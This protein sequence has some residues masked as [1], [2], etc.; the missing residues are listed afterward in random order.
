MKLV[1]KFTL[2]FTFMLVVNTNFAASSSVLNPPIESTTEKQSFKGK[3]KTFFQKKVVQRVKKKIKKVKDSWNL[4]KESKKKGL[5]FMTTL[6]LL[7]TATFVTLQ[8]V[9][10]ISWPWI[11]VLSPLWI[12]LALMILLALVA[13]IAVA[14]MK[15]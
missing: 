7:L 6:I 12:P 14:A 5:G 15:K 13:L 2:L 10:V 8:L 3:V 9:G 1:V 4:Y 11:W